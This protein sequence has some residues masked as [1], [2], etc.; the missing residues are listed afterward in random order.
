MMVGTDQYKCPRCKQTKPRTS[1]FFY[2][3]KNGY[4]HGYCRACMRIWNAEYW[5]AAMTPEQREKHRVVSRESNRRK[6]GIS[7]DRYRVG[8]E[9]VA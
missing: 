1:E 8:R 5:R 9:E 4:V 6:R 3:R 7:P 2:F